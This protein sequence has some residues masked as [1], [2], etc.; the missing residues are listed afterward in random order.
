[1]MNRK[2]MCPLH[3]AAWVLVIFGA[4]NW[5][6][7]GVA[8]LNFVFALLG[9]WPMVERAAYVLVGV[10]A[11]AMVTSGKCCVKGSCRC[12]DGGC[13]HCSMEEKKPSGGQM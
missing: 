11:L 10:A 13:G 12:D 7:V 4:L 9:P 3:K 2:G 5:G 8:K 6:L 1:M